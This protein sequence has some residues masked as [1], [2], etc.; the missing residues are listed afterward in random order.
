MSKIGNIVLPTITTNISGQAVTY[1]NTQQL[2]AILNKI[3]TQL[4]LISSGAI[5]GVWNA[6]AQPPTAFAG[7]TSN[8]TGAVPG[9]R[10]GVGDRIENS[11]PKLLTATDGKQY[12]TT[13]WICIEAGN[14]GTANPPLFY[15]I[16][17]IVNP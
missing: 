6:A 12:I 5:S 11:E 9:I 14:I 10:Y 7:L 15:P 13:G 4:D 8:P 1:A 3:A 16:N 2:Q 17:S